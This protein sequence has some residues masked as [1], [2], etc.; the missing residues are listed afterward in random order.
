MTSL[1]ESNA[2][3]LAAIDT[4]EPAFQKRVRGWCME[5]VNS[6]IPPLIYTGRRTMEEQTALYAIGRSAPGKIVTK[7]RAGE[8]FHNYGLAFDWVPL[9]MSPKNPDL[10]VA[11]WDDETAF[12]LGE[13]VGQSFELAAISFETGHLQAAEYPS[14]RDILHVKVEERMSVFAKPTST[15]RL[16]TRK[17]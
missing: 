17:P 13:H 2:R 7:A 3:T 8:S 14:W 11:D 10:Y 6:K 9:K 4:L 1:A 15:R 5:M 12:R 16:K